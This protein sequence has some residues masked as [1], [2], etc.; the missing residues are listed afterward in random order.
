MIDTNRDGDRSGAPLLQVRG[1]RKAYRS[2]G[3]MLEVLRGVDFEVA[4][5]G[6]VSHG[7]RSAT[8]TMRMRRLGLVILLRS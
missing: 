4:P 6:F 3:G 7:G 8:C 5:A 1:V 2:G